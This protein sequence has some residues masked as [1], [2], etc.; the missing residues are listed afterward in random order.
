VRRRGPHV[1]D[2]MVRGQSELA[3]DGEVLTVSWS[4]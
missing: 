4:G 3:G 1:S 2:D